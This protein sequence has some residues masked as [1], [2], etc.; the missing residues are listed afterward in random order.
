LDAKSLYLGTKKTLKII[1]EIYQ[2][3]GLIDD[4]VKFMGIVE[5]KIILMIEITK[6]LIEQIENI[7]T[8]KQ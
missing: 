8:V 7:E 5:E 4:Y 6:K 2:E 1:S 3:E